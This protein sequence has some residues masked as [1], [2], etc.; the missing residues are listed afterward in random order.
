MCRKNS[1]NFINIL[2]DHKIWGSL[3]LVVWPQTDCKKILAKN[4]NFSQAHLSRSIVVSY[5]RYLNKQ[6]AAC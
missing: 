1:C 4:L 5:L 3:N 6:L 2:Y